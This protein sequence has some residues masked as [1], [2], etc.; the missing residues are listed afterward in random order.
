MCVILFRYNHVRD[1]WI[2][3]KIDQSSH[4][5]L[6]GSKTETVVYTQ[7]YNI[8]L[9]FCYSM[10]VHVSHSYPITFQFS[11]NNFFPHTTAI[12]RPTTGL[13]V[14]VWLYIHHIANMGKGGMS[15]ILCNRS[16]WSHFCSS[17]IYMRS[18]WTLL[19]CIWRFST[20]TLQRHY[21]DLWRH[22]FTLTLEHVIL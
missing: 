3:E 14:N 10:C 12:Q 7:V 21:F 4:Y 13:F 19:N 20:C 16:L 9:L 15:A 6:I 5:F 11:K 22:F 2:R 1:D 18:S 8:L 17:K